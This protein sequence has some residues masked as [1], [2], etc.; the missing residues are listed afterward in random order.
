MAKSVN[1][2]RYEPTQA[3]LLPPSLLDLIPANHPVFIAGQ[4]IDSLDIDPLLAKYRHNPKGGQ[5]PYHPRMLLK[6]LVYGYVSNIYSSRKLE[7]TCRE[8]IYFRWLTGMQTPDHHL[9]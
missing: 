3:F 6:V 9:C 8:S 4:V 1:F 7:A 5:N 2:K